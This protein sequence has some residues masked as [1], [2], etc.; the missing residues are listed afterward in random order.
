MTN[1]KIFF[2]AHFQ[3]LIFILSENNFTHKSW[4]SM[5][6]TQNGKDGTA[7]TELLI[8]LFWTESGTQLE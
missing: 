5:K 2:I 6:T 8:T 1:H 7:Y 4:G 3:I